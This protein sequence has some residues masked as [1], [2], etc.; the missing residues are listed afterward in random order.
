ME[1]AIGGC[2]PFVEAAPARRA[3][4]AI[5]IALQER[6]HMRRI[7]KQEWHVHQA[8]RAGAVFTPAGNVDRQRRL[9]VPPFVAGV[10][11]ELEVVDVEALGA[12]AQ[13]HGAV[14]YRRALQRRI[15]HHDDRFAARRRDHDQAGERE[16]T[17]D[18]RPEK[19][20]SARGNFPSALALD[21]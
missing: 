3:Q 10:E 19:A 18:A 7:A 13:G 9:V 4:I 21:D 17:D 20:G 1:S 11:N 16:S 12:V 6:L 14:L 15:F 5:E 8:K 2:E